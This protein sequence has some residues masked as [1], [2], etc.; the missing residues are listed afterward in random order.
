MNLEEKEVI[1]QI[2]RL[3]S[4][5]E[6]IP[7]IQ[8]IKNHEITPMWAA[9]TAYIV[10][11][12]YLNSINESNQIAFQEEMLYW[13]NLMLKD[14]TGSSYIETINIKPTSD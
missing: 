12:T 14:N 2:Y 4:K 7:A 9:A 10:M 5:N 11:D 6:W 13:F 1:F 3:K 8:A